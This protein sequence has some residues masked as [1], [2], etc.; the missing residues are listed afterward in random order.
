MKVS[1]NAPSNSQLIDQT[2]N[3]EKSSKLKEKDPSA[4]KAVDTSSGAKVDVSESAILMKRAA[5][6]AKS[7]PDVRH[8]KVA[9]LKKRIQS[10]TYQIQ[11]D[12]IAERI[13]S[14]HLNTDFGKNNF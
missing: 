8:D 11:N 10:G 6:M 9:D 1:N 5:E 7:A 13:L 4:Q 12:Q 14:D 2:R 3:A